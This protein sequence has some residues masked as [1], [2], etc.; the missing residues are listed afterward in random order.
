MIF[1]KV[2]TIMTTMAMGITHSRISYFIG[3]CVKNHAKRH[4]TLTGVVEQ[5]NKTA[6]ANVLA[7]VTI[8]KGRDH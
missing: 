8:V 6:A 3:I 5:T 4:E 1:G 7:Y 2:G